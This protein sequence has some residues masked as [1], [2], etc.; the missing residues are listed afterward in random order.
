MT[1]Y[2]RDLD[3]EI[4]TD[5]FMGK[6]FEEALRMAEAKGYDLEVGTFFSVI[7]WVEEAKEQLV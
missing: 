3:E 4:K 2:A 6:G 7:D 5:A 1:I